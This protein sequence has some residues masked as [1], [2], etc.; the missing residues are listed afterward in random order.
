MVQGNRQ[1]H[2]VATRRKQ[3]GKAADRDRKQNGKEADRGRKR[4]IKSIQSNGR[5]KQK[6]KK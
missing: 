5:G 4:K 2:K 6:K 3:R 1:P